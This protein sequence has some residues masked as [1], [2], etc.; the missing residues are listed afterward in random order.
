MRQLFDVAPSRDHLGNMSAQPAIFPDGNAA[1][2]TTDGTGARSLQYA[3]WGWKKVRFRGKK[4]ETWLTNI[5]NLD[6]RPW[7]M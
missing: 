2:V 1:I 5:R 7:H 6:G 3:R 4:Y